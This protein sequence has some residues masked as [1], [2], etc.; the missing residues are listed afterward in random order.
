MLLLLFI[1]LFLFFYLS[2]IY[3]AAVVTSFTALF[4]FGRLLV[5]VFLFFVHVTAV[6]LHSFCC[7]LPQLLYM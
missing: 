6:H 1:L 5:H 2:F 3:V 7:S 4:I